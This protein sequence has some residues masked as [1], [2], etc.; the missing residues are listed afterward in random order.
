MNLKR[1][2]NPESRLSMLPP[3]LLWA[4]G[5][6]P[7]VLGVRSI[8]DSIVKHRQLLRDSRYKRL[9]DSGEYTPFREIVKSLEYP[10][11][12]SNE[13]GSEFKRIY[14]DFEEDKPQTWKLIDPQIY[15]SDLSAAMRDDLSDKAED[16]FRSNVMNMAEKTKFNA[17]QFV[18]NSML[19]SGPTLKPKD[20]DSKGD[21]YLVLLWHAL[22]KD[23][24]LEYDNIVE[25]AV[26]SGQGTPDERTVRDTQY[27]RA[28]AYANYF[29]SEYLK[30]RDANG[31]DEGSSPA[32]ESDGNLNYML[33]LLAEMD[34]DPFDWQKVIISINKVVDLVHGRGSLAHLFVEGGDEALDKIA[35][36]KKNTG[37][38]TAGLDIN[39]NFID[40]DEYTGIKTKAQFDPEKTWNFQT[41]FEN[42]YSHQN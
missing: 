25:Y 19:T 7:N 31:K 24:Y 22:T 16:Y 21:N 9:I 37:F 8:K 11:N 15:G 14:A 39:G 35:G 34:R 38:L 1:I 18:A 23:P 36:Y 2:Y 42:S 32:K 26:S 27:H 20:A 4:K 6:T 30:S 3:L 28:R 40:V 29:S 17:A 13:V 41:K 33:E 10:S 5:Y 12:G